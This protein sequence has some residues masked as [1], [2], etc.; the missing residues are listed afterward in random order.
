MH[1]SC[2]CLALPNI[3][4]SEHVPMLEAGV[5]PF[6]VRILIYVY[7]HQEANVRWNGSVSSN[8]TVRNGC[9]QGKVLAAIA[10]CM[11]C[12]ELFAILKRRRSGCWV[13]GYYCGIFG[14]SDD[15]W[16]LAPSLS[17]LKD[18]LVTLEEHA[19]SH[20]LKFS[21][22]P[23]PVQFKTKCMTFL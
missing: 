19:D 9:G 8:F 3:Q 16:V 6:F 2:I 10:Y 23:N 20:N 4:V 11:Y 15:N 17:T 13:G 5:C 12:E 1:H 22:L 18:I 14:Y 7:A 21:T